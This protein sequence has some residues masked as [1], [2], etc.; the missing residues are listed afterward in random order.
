MLYSLI[1]FLYPISLR[2][3]R[4]RLLW[5]TSN[6]PINLAQPNRG[7]EPAKAIAGAVEIKTFLPRRKLPAGRKH[8]PVYS[9]MFEKLIFSSLNTVRAPLLEGKFESTMSN[10]S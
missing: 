6:Q 7:R 1:D 10:A 4:F 9:D 5:N 2:N 8:C 3:K